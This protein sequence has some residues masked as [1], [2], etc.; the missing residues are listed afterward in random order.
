MLQNVGLSCFPICRTCL[1]DPSS[2]V[3]NLS[4]RMYM[5]AASLMSEISPFW[6]L[7]LILVMLHLSRGGCSGNPL[8][9]GKE[10]HFKK[11]LDARFIQPSICMGL[12]PRT[13]SKEVQAGTLVPGYRHLHK[14]MRKDVFPFPLIDECLDTLFGFSK[15]DANLA[16][17]QI[18]ILALNRKKTVL[19][20]SLSLCLWGMVCVMPLLPFQEPWKNLVLHG[21]G[22]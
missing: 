2:L 6:S 19:W 17:H 18:K 4:S 20:Y 8:S 16:L 22:G 3:C 21:V 11:M 15:L 12:G 7:K 9:L 13:H 14:V 1:R 10:A 5:P